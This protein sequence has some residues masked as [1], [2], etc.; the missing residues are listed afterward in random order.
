MQCV[1]EHSS[2]IPSDLRKTIK[3]SSKSKKAL[4]LLEKEMFKNPTYKHLVGTTQ[5]IDLI[6][7]GVKTNALPEQAWAVVNHRIS[8]IRFV[9]NIFFLQWVFIKK[10]QFCRG[11]ERSRFKPVELPG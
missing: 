9:L 2:D 10:K 7:G 8:V 1:G 3:R 6:Q 5:A 4:R 11:C